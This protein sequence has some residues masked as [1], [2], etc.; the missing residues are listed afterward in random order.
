MLLAAMPFAVEAAVVVAAAFL[1]DDEDAE[2]LFDTFS[3][4]LKHL[5]NS[6]AARFVK[7]NSVAISVVPIS[8]LKK[9]FRPTIK[10][11]SVPL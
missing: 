9:V 6:A 3:P 1:V 8:N 11:S 2:F 4:T 10:Q 7:L 5:D